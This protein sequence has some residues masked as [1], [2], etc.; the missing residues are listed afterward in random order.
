MIDTSLPDIKGSPTGVRQIHDALVGASRT[1]APLRP[2]YDR[3]NACANG[4]E[5]YVINAQ[6]HSDGSCD[7]VCWQSRSGIPWLLSEM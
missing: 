7:I 3:R 5:T 2:L 6:V 4:G 1:K